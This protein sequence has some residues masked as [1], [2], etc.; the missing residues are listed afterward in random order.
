MISEVLPT[1]SAGSATLGD[2]SQARLIIQLGPRPSINGRTLHRNG[3]MG[4]GYRT[5]FVDEGINW[6]GDTAQH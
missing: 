2:T 6:G 3:I 1:T 4:G 5:Y